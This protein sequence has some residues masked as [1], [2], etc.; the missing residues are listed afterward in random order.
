MDQLSIVEPRVVAYLQAQPAFASS[1]A[2]VELSESSGPVE[3]LKSNFFGPQVCFQRFAC[4]CKPFNDVLSI[5]LLAS[6]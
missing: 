4:S 1:N 2:L 5:W 6:Y 3:K